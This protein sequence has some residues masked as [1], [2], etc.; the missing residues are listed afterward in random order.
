[1]HAMKKF[2]SYALLV[3][4][5]TSTVSTAY[6][7]YTHNNVSIIVAIIGGCVFLGSLYGNGFFSGWL[8]GH[9]EQRTF[10]RHTEEE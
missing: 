8:S 6:A 9:E 1:M 5:M 3:A 10:Y 4:L 7:V 2:T